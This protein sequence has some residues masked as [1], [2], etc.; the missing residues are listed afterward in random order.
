[1]IFRILAEVAK[2]LLSVY[3]FYQIKVK[4]EEEHA[5]MKMY[6]LCPTGTHGEDVVRRMEITR[7]RGE[8]RRYARE[9]PYVRTPVLADNN[10]RLRAYT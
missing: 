8:S 1:M 5:R 2:R 9:V 3:G 10:A 7:T 6:F 4:V